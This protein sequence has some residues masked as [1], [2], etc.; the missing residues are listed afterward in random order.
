VALTLALSAATAA[1]PLPAIAQTQSPEA[2]NF[3][4]NQFEAS[5]SG[6]NFFVIQ[7]TNARAK[8]LDFSAMVLVDYARNPL[9]VYTVED[10]ERG[11]RAGVVV[12][13]QLN[14]HVAASLGFKFALLSLDLP[15]AL[16][17]TGDDPSPAGTAGFSSPSGAALGDLRVGLRVPL[18]QLGLAPGKEAVFAAALTGSL[19][20]PT[21]DPAAFTSDGSVRGA[22]G[23]SLGGRAGWLRYG[24]NGGISLR[25]ARLFAQAQYGTQFTFGGGIA[26]VLADDLLQVGPEVYGSTVIDNGD[27]FGRRT[28]N[29]E[30]ILGTR[31]RL[32]PLVL[33]G[34]A[35]PGLAKAAGTPAFR[36]VLSLAYAPKDDDRDSD[37]VKDRYDACPD[38]AGVASS[39]P[40]LNGCPDRDGDGISD[41]QD[42]CPETMGVHTDDPKTN[43]CPD[44]DNDAIVD[45][46]DACPDVVGV[47]DP[48][49]KKHGCPSDLDGD[50]IVDAQDACP[51]VAG[52]F[53]E[54]PAKNGCPDTDGDGL[55]DKVDACPDLEGVASSDPKENGCPPDTD[56]D[57]VRD[58]KDACPREK[59]VADP[60]PAKNGCPTMVRVT[61][62]KIEI[63]QQVQFKT[64]SEVL[65]AASDELLQQVAAVLKEHPEIEQVLVEGHTDN[66]GM[67]VHNQGLSQRRAASVVQW[68]VAHGVEAGRLQSKGIG[69]EVPIADNKTPE[70]RQTNRRVE[71]KIL[72]IQ[73]G[74]VAPASG[75]PAPGAPASQVAPTS[76]I[77]PTESTP[78]TT[79]PTP[80]SLR[81]PI[82]KL[83]VPPRTP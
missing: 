53:S 40:S 33:G 77:A 81:G 23:L 79:P 66:V 25:P 17:N 39:D 55:V 51:D 2:G 15:I 75:A 65:L 72:Q 76:P 11:E 14:L 52:P 46:Q 29:V 6:D 37:G 73:G 68:L 34:G 70:G 44:R 60:D 47:G 38:V 28:T 19:W 26:A 12:S 57:G 1:V 27:V 45:G 30:G 36:A 64:G 83:P 54:D 63:L 32:G 56:G 41:A 3:A 21:G 74:E 13:D 82:L 71:F 50:R 20:V 24:I 16:A 80:P 31:V 7:D 62:G 43:G 42:A 4:L 35:G 59:G 58:D 8:A 9:A 22:P 18:V 61:A 49:P 69:Q 48:D 78:S 5:P 10:G 67:K